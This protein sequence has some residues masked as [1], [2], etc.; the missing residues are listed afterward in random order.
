MYLGPK[1]GV[2]R[3]AGRWAGP[4]TH[5]TRSPGRG[6]LG[7]TEWPQVLSELPLSEPPLGPPGLLSAQKVDSLPADCWFQI[8]MLAPCPHSP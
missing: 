4:D 3:R 1:E 7:G 5:V 8:R 2:R 6:L